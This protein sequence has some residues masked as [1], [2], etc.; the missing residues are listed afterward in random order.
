MLYFTIFSTH[1]AVFG[2]GWHPITQC[3]EGFGVQHT[4]IYH[5]KHLDSIQAMSLSFH[6]C[7]SANI[8][9]DCSYTNLQLAITTCNMAATKLTAIQP[10]WHHCMLPKC[11]PGLQYPILIHMKKGP[12]CINQCKAQHVQTR[13]HHWQK[14]EKLNLAFPKGYHLDV[15]SNIFEWLKGSCFLE[16][17]MHICVCTDICRLASKTCLHIC[18]VNTRVISRIFFEMQSHCTHIFQKSITM[19]SEEDHLLPYMGGRLVGVG[20]VFAQGWS[21]SDALIPGLYSMC[22][23]L[24]HLQ[25]PATC[26][27]CLK[28]CISFGSTTSSCV[29]VNSS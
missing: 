10:A 25:V 9:Q 1:C 21:G 23:H 5:P 16:T 24:S 18:F 20:W 17:C 19:H 6:Q 26:H 13:M 28:S 7:H 8:K 29:L 2:Y 22:T 12:H 15:F 27:P 3:W 14:H 11:L 4:I